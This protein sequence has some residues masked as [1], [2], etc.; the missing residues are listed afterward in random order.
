MDSGVRSSQGLIFVNS[1]TYSDCALLVKVLHNNFGLKARIQY[2]G[3]SS[4]YSIYFP[5]E[6][7]IDLRNKVSTYIIPEMK[8]KLLP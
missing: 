2:K 1:F 4:Q 6:S 7:M 5:K 8:Y 3:V